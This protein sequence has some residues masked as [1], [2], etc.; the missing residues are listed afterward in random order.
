MS[1]PFGSSPAPLEK[2]VDIPKQ[3]YAL[4][5]LLGFEDDGPKVFK[6]TGPPQSNVFKSKFG[7]RTESRL[8]PRYNA[9]KRIGFLITLKFNGLCMMPLGM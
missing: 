4:L 7:M 8:G 9:W 2:A 6:L 3:R 1:T 5:L